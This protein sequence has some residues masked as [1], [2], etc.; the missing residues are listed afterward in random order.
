MSNLV[1]E[2]APVEEPPAYENDAEA[3]AGAN[4]RPRQRIHKLKRT[5]L[6][7]LVGTTALLLGLFKCGFR[8]PNIREAITDHM[9]FR[10][11]RISTGSQSLSAEFDLLDLLSIH[12]TSGSLNIGI[13]PQPANK[14]NPLPAEV[15]IT[16]HSGSINVNFP[17]FS[18]PEREYH[19]SISS[20]SGRIDGSILHGRRTSLATRSGSM[21]VRLQLAAGESDLQT[22]TGSGSQYIKVLN[23][24]KHI[25]AMSS[26]HSSTSGS[27]ALRYPREWEGMIEGRTQSGSWGFHGGGVD[28]IRRSGNYVLARKGNGSSTLRFRTGSGSVNVY[29]D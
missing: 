11:R 2:K 8:G 5:F 6:L 1:V 25:Q 18:I 14:E 16:S 24:G 13:H 3:E 20:Q 22:E 19:V 15:S 12:S 26:T 10:K 9:D 29:F 7:A 4:A 27:L 28:I 23:T 21:N 17:T